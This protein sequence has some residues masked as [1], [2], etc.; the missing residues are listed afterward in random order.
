MREVTRSHK[1]GISKRKLLGFVAYPQALSTQQK[2]GAASLI[3][4]AVLSVGAFAAVLD[5]QAKTS[6]ANDNNKALNSSTA[7]SADKESAKDS[8]SAA[9]SSSSLN[10]NLNSSSQTSSGDGGSNSSS[11]TLNV[12]GQDIPV[13]NNG[14]VHQSFTSSDGNS[15]VDLNVNS[16]SSTSSGGQDM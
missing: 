4:A 7:V 3:M 5:V 15:H 1:V 13:A 10:V 2:L 11:T 12:N 8:S 9:G 16:S 6:S 14:N